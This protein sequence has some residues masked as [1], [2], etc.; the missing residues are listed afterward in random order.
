MKK[1]LFIE[2]NTTGT[3]M[4]ALI[5]ARELGFTPVLLTNNPGRYIGLGETKCIVLEC[6]TNNLNC[7][8][9][10]IDSEFEVG[11]IKAITTTSEFYIE[12]VAILAKE[13]GLIGNPI[14]TVKKCRN[15][16]EM[17]LLL[18]GIENIY[19]PWFYIIDSL[20]K[21]ELAKDN[22]KFP[23]VVKPV[24]DSGSNN[25]LKCYSYEEVKR[26]TEK[27]LSNKYNVRSQ[28]NAQNILVEEYVSGQEYSVEIFTYNGKCKIVGVTQ[29]IVDGAPYFIEC[30]HIF[31]APVSDDI[32]SVI[33][34]GVTKIIEKVNWQ[35]GPC[36]LEIKIKGEK[37][38]L[39]EFNGRLAGGM[40]P[41]LIKYAT[42]I[43]LLKEQL[44]VVT[45]MRPKLDQNP[46]LYAGIRFI[47]P[48]RDGK[49]TSIFG[50]N[51]IENTV[52]IKEVKLRTIVGESIRKVENAYGRIGHIIG[53]A[54]N[55]NKLN[56]ILDK[57]MDALHIEIEEC[58]DYEDFN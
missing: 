32:R 45:R 34:R 28:K 33:E 40:I 6:D 23:C 53:A 52:G 16:A 44:K 54:E 36:H 17:R 13:L 12:V 7:I 18:K 29:K 11:E 27:I 50:V 20:E 49:I 55:I 57:S 37:I 43:D 15:K 47:I 26:H 48:L 58:E 10:I 24:D 42:G 8:R 22:I 35:N 19:E 39:V 31:P 4:L 5:K 30:G 56:Y 25:V 2:S 1:L 21:L 9:T 38:F 46:T 51:D 3:G 41:E 14:D